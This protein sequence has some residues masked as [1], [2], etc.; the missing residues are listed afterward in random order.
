MSVRLKF[1]V[2]KF[3]VIVFVAGM[4][5]LGALLPDRLSAGEQSIVVLVNGEP[6]TSYDVTQ[7]Q[8]FLALVSGAVSKAIHAKLQS[9]EVKIQFRKFMEQER[10]TTR[11]EAVELQ[12][13]FV[14]RLQTQAMSEVTPKL[15]KKAIDELVEEHLMLQEAKRLKV[16]PSESEVNAQLLNMAQARDKSG[17]LEKFFSVFKAQGV[18][19]KTIK[20]RVRAQLAWRNVIRKLYGYKIVALLGSTDAASGKSSTSIEDWRFDLHVVRV[21]VPA[22]ASE[23]VTAQ[24]YLQGESLREQ[25]SSCEKLPKLVELLEDASLKTFNKAKASSFPPEVQA[26]LM[27][28]RAG[29]MLPPIVSGD[30]INLYAVCRKRSLA[31][32][33]GKEKKAK[34][35]IDRRQQEF[36]LYARRHLKDLKQEALIEYR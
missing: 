8:G 9:E 23:R 25:F 16:E 31:K 24:R 13:K 7:R 3:A 19:P 33:T 18:D 11:E 20:E 21:K 35:P 27:K 26:M 34:R 15:R 5:F 12:K 36:Q 28:A 6:V 10:P 1:A 22:G 30:A 17:T 32:S 2:I 14:A 29:Q 4:C